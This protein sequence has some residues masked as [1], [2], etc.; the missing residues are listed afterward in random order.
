[1]NVYQ[2]GSL[3]EDDQ[4]CPFDRSPTGPRTSRSAGTPYVNWGFV[5]FDSIARMTKKLAGAVVAAFAS[6]AVGAAPAVAAPASVVTLTVADNGRQ[7]RVHRGTH[8]MVRLAVNPHQD[9]DP[10]TWWHAVSESGPALRARPQTLMAARGRTLGHY[11][12]VARGTAT[13]SSSRAVCPQTGTGPTCHA[14]QGWNVTVEV[15]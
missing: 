4:V 1:M 3:P 14:M 11:L 13:L 2:Q 6:L 10:T 9:P 8:I 5:G 7:V 15:R 12:A